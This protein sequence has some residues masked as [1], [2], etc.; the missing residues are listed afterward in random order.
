MNY[1]NLGISDYNSKKLYGTA[2]PERT[3]V[4]DSVR[5]TYRAGW[6]T[7]EHIAGKCELPAYFAE[8]N[9][10]YLWVARVVNGKPLY[11]ITQSKQ[12]LGQN[13]NEDLNALM[14]EHDLEWWS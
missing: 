10:Q 5:A 2:L 6:I 11:A 13:L 7:A 14:K 4:N 1:F 12:P 9:G 3:A 8:I